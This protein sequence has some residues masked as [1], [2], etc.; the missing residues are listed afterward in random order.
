MGDKTGNIVVIGSLNMDMVAIVD[1]MPKTG[2]TII[3][4]DLELI[5]GG[6]GA[7]QAYAMAKPVSYTHLKDIEKRLDNRGISLSITAAAKEFIADAAYSPVYLS[8]IH[9]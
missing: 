7:N 9:I 5:P 2:Q 1:E 8:L 4:K 6:K 3:G